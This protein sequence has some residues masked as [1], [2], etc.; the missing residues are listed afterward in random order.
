MRT[1]WKLFK[2]AL[3]LAIAIPLGLIVLATTMGILGALFG[4]A[5][6]VLK[7]AFVG[8]IAYG[9]F[10]LAR[11]LFFGPAPKP[12]PKPAPAPV[13]PQLPPRDPYYEAAM[14]ELDSELRS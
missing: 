5:V 8:L 12:A 10:K 2:I 4:L 9:A 11:N 6:L 1:V 7:L 14:R 13:V 3:A